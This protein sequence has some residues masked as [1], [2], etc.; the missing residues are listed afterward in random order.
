MGDGVDEGCARTWNILYFRGF[1]GSGYALV[2]G[3]EKLEVLDDETTLL[4]C[5]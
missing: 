2:S 1:I 4:W 5:I 3:K